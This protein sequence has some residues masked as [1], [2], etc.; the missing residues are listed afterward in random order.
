LLADGWFAHA[1]K[2]MLRVAGEVAEAT[3]IVAFQADGAGT[4][5]RIAE[6][7]ATGPANLVR[8]SLT[9][10]FSPILLVWLGLNGRVVR[11][12][13]P[14]FPSLYRGGLHHAEMLAVSALHQQPV[15]I[16]SYMAEL[17]AGFFQAEPLLLSQIKV[18]LRGANGSEHIFQPAVVAA[19]RC[20]FGI[21]LVAAG[22]ATGSSLV[23]DRLGTAAATPAIA[24][25]RTGGA[26]L[27]LPA[28]CL[29]SL[30]ALCAARDCA[31]IGAATFC[32]VPDTKPAEATLATLPSPTAAMQQ[33]SHPALPLPQPGWQSG[34][35]CAAPAQQAGLPSAIRTMNDT[36][37]QVDPL[38]PLSPDLA[39]P[40]QAEPATL[41]NLRLVVTH[42]ATQTQLDLCLRAI[43][44]QS[45][46]QVSRITILADKPDITVPLDL[47]LPIEFG[48]SVAA[49]RDVPEG[50]EQ[51]NVVVL[52]DTSVF[53]HDRRT[54]NALGRLCSAEGVGMASCAVVASSPEEGVEEA[55]QVPWVADCTEQ[56]ASPAGRVIAS[57]IPAAT[58]AV[59]AGDPR[60]LAVRAKLWEEFQSSNQSHQPAEMALALANHCHDKGLLTV[61]TTLVRVATNSAE[62]SLGDIA[63]AIA[64]TF[65]EGRSRE[66]ATHLIRL[67]P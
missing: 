29:P 55:A 21:D 2:L 42:S 3:R 56:P 38:M 19:L 50:P 11:S 14:L 7:P 39:W 53:P 6:Q 22:E 25:R 59:T 33:L 41:P 44:A 47:A 35:G 62:P 37:W 5:C 31:R 13:L 48:T 10:P 52:I 57:L 8:L 1:R 32:I 43:A 66:R 49:G 26:E 64:A 58:F 54:L 67:M 45:E 18:H 36:V 23:A 61:A 34:S 28:D 46:V 60:I 20:H 4:I 9:N 15:A 40:G 30:I 24:E 17:A 27:M 12:A 51:E 65:A 63:P 16:P